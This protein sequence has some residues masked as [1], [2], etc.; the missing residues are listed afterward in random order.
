ML[1]M[2][3]HVLGCAK[4]SGMAVEVPTIPKVKREK[5]ETLR[6]YTPEQLDELVAAAQARSTRCGPIPFNSRNPSPT[7]IQSRTPRSR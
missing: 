7:A 6:F 4:R 3:G 5:I 1:G 2:L